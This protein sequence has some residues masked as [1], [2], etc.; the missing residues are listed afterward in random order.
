MF[1]LRKSELHLTAKAQELHKRQY[2]A[3]R[4]DPTMLFQSCRSSQG[5]AMTQ[6]GWGWGY[7]P[8]PIIVSEPLGFLYFVST[9]Q[10]PFPSPLIKERWEQIHGLFFVACFVICL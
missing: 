1:I 10:L 7:F 9:F 4:K 6:P 8:V 2:F 3:C 5:C